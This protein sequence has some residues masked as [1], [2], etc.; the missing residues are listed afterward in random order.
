MGSMPFALRRPLLL[1]RGALLNREQP[2]LAYLRSIGDPERFA[3]AILPHVAR[4]FA[5]SIVLLPHPQAQAALVGYLYSRMLDT[6]EDMVPDHDQKSRALQWFA[7]RLATGDLADPAPPVEIS[8][9]SPRQQVD[10][11][12]V[13]R[14]EMV[15]RLYATLRESDQ[16]KVAALVTAMATSMQRWSETFARQGGVLETEQQLREY[17][18]DVIGEPAR[19]A[20]ALVI[21]A[22]ISDSQ[23]RG[24]AT[25]SEMVQLANVTRDIEQDLQ[26][27]IGYHPSLRPYLGAA[28]VHPNAIEQV[29]QVREELLVRALKCVP[30]YSRLLEDLHL[31]AVSAARGSAVLLLLFTDRH[32]RGCAVDA[33]YEPWSGANS[34]VKLFLTSLLS[35]LSS[36]WALRTIRRI[37]DNFL[38]AAHAIER[39][40]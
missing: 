2:D 1:M 38:A 25:I 40:G 12:L 33:G 24:A 13:Q 6:Y 31:P 37:E 17:C 10:R 23:H 7:T 3:W 4:S 36:R 32:Y 28:P 5:A 21:R 27:G 30:A 11:L 8:T 9:A 19:F 15:D 35:A 26:R 39:P 14:C 18:H 34:T 16:A 22:P 29:R 20:L